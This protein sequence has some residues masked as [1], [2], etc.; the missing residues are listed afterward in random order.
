MNLIKIESVR[1]LDGF[2]K[3]KQGISQPGKDYSG[4]DAFS[5]GELFA[6]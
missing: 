1:E 4:E 6:R 3:T 2:S 5:A